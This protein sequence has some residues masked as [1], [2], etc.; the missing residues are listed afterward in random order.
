MPAHLRAVDE[1]VL[2]ATSYGTS[3]VLDAGDRLLLAERPGPAR[4]LAEAGRTI[5]AGRAAKSMDNLQFVARARP[6]AAA[7][8]VPPNGSTGTSGA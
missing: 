3:G 6:R 4:L 5:D 7:G 2:V 1:A 8:V